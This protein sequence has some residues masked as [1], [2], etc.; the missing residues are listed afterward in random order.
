[1]FECSSETLKT[2][3][4]IP[5]VEEEL[6]AFI[7]VKVLISHWQLHVLQNPTENQPNMIQAGINILDEPLN[8][9]DFLHQSWGACVHGCLYT[10]G[11]IT[12][13]CAWLYWKL[14]VYVEYS[15]YVNVCI[16]IHA[17]MYDIF[18]FTNFL[19]YKYNILYIPLNYI[20]L[21]YIILYYIILYYIIF[22]SHLV[23]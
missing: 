15:S 4:Q 8:L 16:C 14:Y 5:A 19:I 23:V 17:F 18:H 12:S 7:D 13:Y 22:Q 3:K 6:R 21:Y 10:S 11:H 9:W 1:M 2:Q 20:I